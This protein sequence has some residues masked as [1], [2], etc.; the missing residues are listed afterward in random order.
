[1]R[2]LLRVAMEAAREA[3]RLQLQGLGR[4]R[5][6]EFKGELN[7]VTEVDRACEE[8]IISLIRTRFPDHD[9]LTEETPL[10]PKGSPFRW[11]VDPLDGTTNYAHGYPIFCV[12]IALQVEGQLTFGV[13]YDPTRDEMFWAQ[14][15]E[16]AYLNGRRIGVSKTNKLIR[17]LLSTGFPYDLR[18]SPVNNL[19]HFCN[20]IMRAQAVRRDG[21]AALNLCYVAA[22]RF[23]G[24]WELKL[25]PWDVAAGAIIVEEAGG[26]VTD[27]DGNPPDIFGQEIVASNGLI[28]QEMLEVLKEGKRPTTG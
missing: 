1:M 19:D 22:G 5:K 2:D 17:S 27:F 25:K 4:E 16:G 12:S 3:G 21:A 28:H 15:G 10:S 8:R 11:I 26:E 18:E 13:V 14:R 7:L 20:M 6:V 23:D 24:F 9:V